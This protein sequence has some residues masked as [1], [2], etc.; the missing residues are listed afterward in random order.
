MKIAVVFDHDIPIRSFLLSGVLK[1]LQAK[2]DVVFIFPQNHR[3]VRLDLGIQLTQ[4]PINV[5]RV[6][7]DEH[8]AFLQRRLYQATVLRNSRGGVE[9]DLVL[10]MW[11]EMLGRRGYWE[12][13]AWS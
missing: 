2:H 1:P 3:R 6:P 13:W 12:T 4:Y 9:S 7:V 5:R 11:R 8:R 10:K